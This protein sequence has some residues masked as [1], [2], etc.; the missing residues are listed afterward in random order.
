MF[1][2]AILGAFAAI[3]KGEVT[4]MFLWLAFVG[5]TAINLLKAR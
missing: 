5:Y 2:A 4:E 3:L 1:V